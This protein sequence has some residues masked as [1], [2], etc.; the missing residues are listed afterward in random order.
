MER[1]CLR[2][3]CR[4]SLTTMNTTISGGGAPAAAA[5]GGGGGGG[6]GGTAN[7]AV[8]SQR[9]KVCRAAAAAEEDFINGISWPPRSYTCNFCKREFRSAQA[10]GGH[11][12]VHRRDRAL[13]YS[14]PADH[15]HFTNLNLNLHH[16]P[17]PNRPFKAL[18]IAKPNRNKPHKFIGLDIE[19]N[20][21]N[22]TA[23]LLTE[24]KKKDID[25][26]LRLGY[27]T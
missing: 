14:P 4:T 8:K 3:A 18:E 27:S 7:A 2:T 17:F 12:N 6:G 25:L 20:T 5:A 21:T 10:L 26:E 11:M 23:T 16:N 9:N 13:L 19:I 1:N 22:N 24:S 15:T